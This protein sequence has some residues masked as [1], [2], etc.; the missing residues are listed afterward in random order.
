[1]QVLGT[2]IVFG[3]DLMKLRLIAPLV[4]AC[5]W[6]GAA[7]SAA[8]QDA[9]APAA[10][11]APATPASAP[12]AA[13]AGPLSQATLAPLASDDFDA[14]S[15][16]LDALLQ[17]APHD[18]AARKLLQALQ[19][20][21]VYVA[22]ASHRLLIQDGK[23]YVDA[24]TGQAAADPGNDA[25]GVLLNNALRSKVEGVMASLQLLDADRAVRAKAIGALADSPDPKLLPLLDQALQQEKDAELKTR[26]E[27]I[28][29][30]SALKGSDRTLQIKAVTLLGKGQNPQAPALLEPLARQ[31]DNP[32][33][34]AAARQALQDI[35]SKQRTGEVLGNL[36]QGVSAASILLLAALGLAITYGLMGVINMAHGEFLMIGAYATYWVQGMFRLHFPG[37]M[38]YYVLAALPV[39]FVAAALVGVAIEWVVLRHLYNRPLETLLA[40]FGVSLL[41]IQ[42][43]RTIFGAQNVE[44]ANPRWLSGGWQVLPNLVLPYNRI[45]IIVFSAMVLVLAWLVINRTRL[46]LFVRAVTQNRTM[47]GCVGVRVPKIDRYAFAFGA[48]IAGLGGVALSQ[49]GASVV[50]DMG[51]AYIIDSFMTVVLGGVGQ[52]AG[53][54]TGALGLGILSKLIEPY[55][56]AVLAK[57]AVLVLVIVFIQRRPQ[58]IF[59][60]KGR[61]VEA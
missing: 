10:A 55:W 49:V 31:T 13:A 25:Q 43:V 6:L 12:H 53:T 47:A 36:F 23:A 11:S 46:G 28:W 40:T 42:A 60:L 26:L 22:G 39:A 37:A 14:K 58:G 1:M 8:A 4:A 3:I 20:D 59:A 2:R 38:D 52:L 41:L 18:A 54:V 33:L 15:A 19:N 51:K 34:A 44:V 5:V 56:G 32:E 30:L 57:I 29:A 9:S 45:A 35:H 21:A 17:A 7:G 16:A 24:A 50:P 61:S 27:T 48:G